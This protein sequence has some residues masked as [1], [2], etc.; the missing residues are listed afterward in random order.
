M[1]ITLVAFCF[2]GPIA[3]LLVQ[4]GKSLWQ[5]GHFLCPIGQRSSQCWHFLVGQFETNKSDAY[6]V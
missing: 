6:K 1:A 3:S 5:F 2:G 4:Q